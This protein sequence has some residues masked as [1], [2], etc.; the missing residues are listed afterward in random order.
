[1]VLLNNKTLDN[2]ENLSLNQHW[3]EHC[4]VYTFSH[5]SSYFEIDDIMEQCAC[6]MFCMKPAKETNEMLKSTFAEETLRH[7]KTFK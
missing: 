3:A 4:P 6:I 2:V 1:M 5:W 7:T